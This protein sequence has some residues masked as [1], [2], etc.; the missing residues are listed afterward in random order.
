MPE[1]G[2]EGHKT[3][4]INSPMQHGLLSI[5]MTQ[6][7]LI[8]RIHMGANNYSCFLALL[9]MLASGMVVAQPPAYNG[10]IAPID[11]IVAVV[12][13][14]VITQKEL[15]EMLNL[16]VKQLRGRGV[17]PPPHNVLEKQLLERIIVNRIQLQLATE[18]GLT[19]SDTELDKTLHRI[20]D[21]NR[22][23]LA[24]LYASL[25]RDGVNFNKFRT[26]IRDEIIIT[27]L[28]EREVD[29]RVAVNEGEVD[30]FLHA[31]EISAK[32][33]KEYRLAHVLVQ[34]PEHAEAAQ[35]EVRRRRAETALARLRNNA[36]FAQVTAEFSDA[37]DAMTGGVL[38]WRPST[39]LPAKFAEILA[40]MHPGELTPVIRSQN[41][42]HILKLLDQR[43]Q[44]TSVVI[45]SQ[46]NSRHILIKISELTSENDAWRRIVELKERL[47]NGGNFQ[48]LAKLH[49][50]DASASAGGNLGWISPGDTVPAFEQAMNALLP[51]QISGPVQSPF[52]WHL[53]QVV[54]R[55]T[56]DVSNDRQR[57]EARR[58]IHARKADTAF[59]EWVQRLRDRA[60][61]E[62]R[63]DER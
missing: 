9:L 27:R 21:E 24:E 15:N 52:G 36:E 8:T 46:T 4:S 49:S 54:E 10:S 20:A 33:I 11:S 35:I 13:E 55:R 32:G 44:K 57:Q 47:D 3:S 6:Q 51:G 61:V 30:N 2:E 17:Q 58:A 62:Y 59:Q 34:V 23:S 53:I 63:L 7:L 45:I 37:P 26:E 38:D 50:D 60:Y 25:E 22:M 5:F 43:G 48:E 12:N 39:Q 31:Q 41:A 18:T 28:K 14:D 42:F 40:T 1:N 16:T 56:Q 19:V 29:N